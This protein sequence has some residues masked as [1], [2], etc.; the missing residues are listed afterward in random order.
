MNTRLIVF[1][2]MSVLF[3]VKRGISIYEDSSYKFLYAIPDILKG[4]ISSLVVVG[5]AYMLFM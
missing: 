5:L 4:S 2:I 3:V 1:I